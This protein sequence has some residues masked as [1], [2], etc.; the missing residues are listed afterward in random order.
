MATHGGARRLE[1]WLIAGVIALAIVLL[2]SACGSDTEGE[3]K[4]APKEEERGPFY[5][6]AVGDGTPFG[7]GHGTGNGSHVAGIYE[8]MEKGELSEADCRTIKQQFDLVDASV[9]GLE[10]R[11]AAEAAGWRQIAQYIPGLGTHHIKGSIRDLFN[12]QFDAANPVFLIYGGLEGDA[13]APLVGVGYLS[14]GAS[15]PPEAFAGTN[16]WWHLHKRLC[17][18]AN[19]DIL[20]G[21][22]EIPDEECTALGGRQIDLGAGIWLLHLWMV[23]DYELKLDVF[24]SGHPCMGETGPIDR[25]DPCW[26]HVARHPADGPPEGHTAEGHGHD[27]D[28]ETS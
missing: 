6:D 25:D 28:E 10:T 20:A 9:K 7:D 1:P 15:D 14:S 27:A 21:A 5:C 26:D 3:A 13:D 17:L 12:A 4:A 11:G 2:A 23:P 8:G 19:G 24:A 16:D 22:E 18:G